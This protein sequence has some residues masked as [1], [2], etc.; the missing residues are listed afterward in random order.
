MQNR[1]TSFEHEAADRLQDSIDILVRAAD[2]K[3]NGG[4]FRWL[5]G[6]YLIGIYFCLV[7]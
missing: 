2:D 7:R 5:L 3:V 4:L 6:Q 1:E